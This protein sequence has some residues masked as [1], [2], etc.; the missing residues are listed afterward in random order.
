LFLAARRFTSLQWGE[1]APKGAGEGDQTVEVGTPHP[2]R[3]LC[4]LGSLSP[5]GRGKIERRAAIS[6]PAS[7]K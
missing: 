5:L 6:A 2:P 7:N 3:S 4:S 1:V